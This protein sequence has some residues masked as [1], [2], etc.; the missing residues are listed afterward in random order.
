MAGPT[1]VEGQKE[2]DDL[3]AHGKYAEAVEAAERW[4]A[5][6]KAAHGDDSTEFADALVALSTFRQYQARYLDARALLEQVRTVY[7]MRLGPN[8]VRRSRDHHARFHRGHAIAR[9]CP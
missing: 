9:Q 3:A 6:A 8:A 7:E 1:P 2:V 4:Q 5:S